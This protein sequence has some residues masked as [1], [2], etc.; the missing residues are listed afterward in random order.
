MEDREHEALLCRIEQNN[1]TKY[2]HAHTAYTAALRISPTGPISH[3]IYANRAA[4]LI[5]LRRYQEAVDDANQ[6]IALKP[7]YGQGHA[8]LGQV[9]HF[10]K[11]YREAVEA[12]EEALK[13]EAVDGRFI[14]M[15]RHN[16]QKAKAKLAKQEG[17]DG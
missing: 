5:F 1:P 17:R 3:I 14:A 7:A 15:T 13:H 11:Q 9:F 12:Y 8:R 6:A 16:L 10:T 2:Q 4:A